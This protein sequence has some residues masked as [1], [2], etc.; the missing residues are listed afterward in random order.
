MTVAGRSPWRATIASTKA[1]RSGRSLAVLVALR[2]RSRRT[3]TTRPGRRPVRSRLAT[4]GCAAAAALTPSRATARA[5]PTPTARHAT[6]GP[7]ARRWTPGRL[8]EAMLVWE[9]RCG[10][11]PSSYD[12]SLTHA[13]RRGGEVLRRLNHGRWPSASVVTAV[14]GSWSAARSAIGA[15]SSRPGLPSDAGESREVDDWALSAGQLKRSAQQRLHSFSRG[16]PFECLSGPS[17]EFGG[18]RRRS[19]RR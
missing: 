19:T 12:W 14:W 5:T 1:F 6:L 8:L 9:L 4:S 15:A 11:L 3:S 7:I 2:R 13:C 16:R 10:R 17:V 18:D